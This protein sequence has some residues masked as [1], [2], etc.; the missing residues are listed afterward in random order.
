MKGYSHFLWAMSL[1]FFPVPEKYISNI[2]SLRY[3]TLTVKMATCSIDCKDTNF[4]LQVLDYSL[5]VQKIIL[6]YEKENFSDT[7]FLFFFFVFLTKSSKLLSKMES[8]TD[9][10]M[11]KL[12]IH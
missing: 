4:T 9:D 2:P 5:V 6:F 11:G 3:A 8:C 12:N 7:F 1:I 10:F